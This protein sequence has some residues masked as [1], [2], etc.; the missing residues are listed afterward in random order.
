MLLFGTHFSTTCC[1]GN[2]ERKSRNRLVPPELVI[3]PSPPEEE[4]EVPVFA[5]ALVPPSFPE[6]PIVF[7]MT[8]DA[9]TALV[10]N[11]SATLRHGRSYLGVDKIA[12]F[13]NVQQD[14]RGERSL[15]RWQQLR[16]SFAR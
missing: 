14:G 4:S 9:T 10:R 2:L 8:L 1:K 6:F 12:P 3:Q 13:K 15:A 16:L 5:S 7:P 11:T